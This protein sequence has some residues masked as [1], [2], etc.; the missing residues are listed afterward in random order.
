MPL[1]KSGSKKAI[2][3]NIRTEM[4]AGKPQKQ[5]VAIALDVARRAKR[6]TGGPVNQKGA[7]L[8]PIV[9]D[10]PGRTDRIPMDV[11]SGSYVVPADIVSGLGEGNTLAGLNKL[12]ARFGAHPFGAPK[13]GRRRA[14]GG[15]LAGFPR[16]ADVG[17]KEA[18]PIIAAGGEFVISPD[19]VRE[20]GGGDI[21][22]G[23]EM[24]DQWILE[25]R[26]NLI[27]TLRKLPGPAKD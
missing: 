4:A 27:E 2:S 12:T 23:H 22:R 13:K 15:S 8:G 6:A 20:L 9:S 5:A 16:E 21:D 1:I 17:T 19:R 7:H 25:T 18:V 3:T 11:P 26:K 14:S 24:L 10:I